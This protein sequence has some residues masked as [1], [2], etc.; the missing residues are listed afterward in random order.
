MT[1][2]VVLDQIQILNSTL[3]GH[4]STFSPRVSREFCCKCPALLTIGVHHI[5]PRVR[6]DREPPLQWDETA[7]DMHVIWVGRESKYFCEGDWTTQIR[8][9]LKENSFSTVIRKVRHSARAHGSSRF[10]RLLLVA[11]DHIGELV[12][13]GGDEVDIALVFDSG[14]RRLQRV[15][16]LGERRR[17]IFSGHIFV[18]LDA[19]D[20][21]SDDGFTADIL[22]RRR[23]E[24]RKGNGNVVDDI[25]IFVIAGKAVLLTL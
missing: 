3:R 5:P 10:E 25:G 1:T 2:A 15:V 13:V 17:F 22:P 12:I 19:C 7:R 8:L 6:D 23:I 9:R 14:R 21:R 16:K 24:T 11:P 18:S 4:N 20:L